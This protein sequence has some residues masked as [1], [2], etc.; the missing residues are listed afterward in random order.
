MGTPRQPLSIQGSSEAPEILETFFFSLPFLQHMEVPRLGVDL[1]LQL[2]P[3]PQQQRQ[4][5]WALQLMPGQEQNLNQLN[6]ARDQTH[7]L[8]ETTLGP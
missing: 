7:I 3:A 2:K 1:D 4:Q 6:K 5:I 8:M